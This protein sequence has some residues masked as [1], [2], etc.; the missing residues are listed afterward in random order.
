[1]EQ[2]EIVGQLNEEQLEALQQLYQETWW[3][4]GRKQA[5]IRRMLHHSDIIVGLCEPIGGKLVG[6]SRILTDYV[7]RATIWDVIVD[8]AY[9]GRGLGRAI[10]QAVIHHPDLQEVETFLLIC[11]PE[12]IAFYEKVGFTTEVGKLQIM[13]RTQK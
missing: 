2:F 13:A 8:P 12:A 1:M 4:K 6:F 10:V 9:Q 7:Y 5:A 3:G 11:L